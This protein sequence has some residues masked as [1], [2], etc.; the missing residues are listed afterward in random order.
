[1]SP[2]GIAGDGAGGAGSLQERGG[3]LRRLAKW[4]DQFRGLA[5]KWVLN[6]K[7]RPFAPAAWQLVSLPFAKECLTLKGSG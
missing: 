5:A 6:R 1:M 2:F 3:A 4:A 7:P